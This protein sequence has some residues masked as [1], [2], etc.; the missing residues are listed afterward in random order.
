MVTEGP[1]AGSGESRLAPAPAPRLVHHLQLGYHVG[2][3]GQ[4]RLEG[5]ERTIVAGILLT[6]NENAERSPVG[7]VN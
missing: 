4:A 2:P 7:H 5:A 1:E 6:D 3:S